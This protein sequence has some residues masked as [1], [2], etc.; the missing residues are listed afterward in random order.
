MVNAVSGANHGLPIQVARRPRDSKT[1]VEVAVIREEEGT[2]LRADAR[3]AR[4]GVR[5]AID[6]ED[7]A[8]V[9]GFRDGSVVF[10]ADSHIQGQVGPHLPLIQKVGKDKGVPQPSAPPGT[11]ELEVV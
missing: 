7:S 6:V 10:P 1:W 2:A 5:T 4:G 11:S 9:V 8:T 3:V